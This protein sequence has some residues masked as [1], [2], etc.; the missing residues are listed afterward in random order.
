MMNSISPI[1]GISQIITFL[2]KNV[3]EVAISPELGTIPANS[4]VN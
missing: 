3:T 2:I 4:P 1:S